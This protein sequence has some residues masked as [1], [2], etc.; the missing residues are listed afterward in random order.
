MTYQPKVVH[1]AEWRKQA[2]LLFET[3]DHLAWEFECPACG[4]RQTGADFVALGITEHED[5][6]GLLGYT[7]I[8]Y[9]RRLLVHAMNVVEVGERTQGAGCMYEG[10]RHQPPLPI[11]V[12]SGERPDGTPAGNFTFNFAQPRRT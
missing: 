3:P 1:A 12:W 5:M 9:F 4:Q 7:C 8:G 10:G 6:N 2:E 11:F